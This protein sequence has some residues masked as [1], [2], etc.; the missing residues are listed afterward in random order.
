MGGNYWV[1]FTTIHILLDMQLERI[2]DLNDR[3][4]VREIAQKIDSMIRKMHKLYHFV[5][6]ERGTFTV[7]PPNPLVHSLYTAMQS[8]LVERRISLHGIGELYQPLLDLENDVHQR[9]SK[10]VEGIAHINRDL[11]KLNE[12]FIR[13]AMGEGD[14]VTIAKL[15]SETY[16]METFVQLY[17]QLVELHRVCIL[18][19]LEVV[20][21]S[22]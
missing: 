7:Q 12:G 2:A 19:P 6:P 16:N 3:Q 14:L 8:N 5:S 1:T 4:R 10:W 20:I 13:M 11:Y 21:K 18:S 22:N 17:D 9:E 15:I